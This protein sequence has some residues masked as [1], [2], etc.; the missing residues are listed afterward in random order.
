[1]DFEAF[2]LLNL[3][4]GSIGFVRRFRILLQRL[5][6]RR[7]MRAIDESLIR[8]VFYAPLVVKKKSCL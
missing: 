2:K 5:G 6:F 3:Q 1:M 8:L 7:Q 4:S